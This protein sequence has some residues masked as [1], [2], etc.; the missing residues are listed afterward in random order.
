MRTWYTYRTVTGNVSF[1]F[2]EDRESFEDSFIM[3][4]SVFYWR[5]TAPITFEQLMIEAELTGKYKV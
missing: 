4:D 3:Q 1:Y 5:D 2:C